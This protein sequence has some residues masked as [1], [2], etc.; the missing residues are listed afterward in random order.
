MNLFAVLPAYNEAANLPPLLASLSGLENKLKPEVQLHVIVVDDGSSDGTAGTVVP[1]KNFAE[2]VQHAKNQGFPAALR[3]GL[4]R[5]LELSG[6]DDAV[7]VMDADNTHPVDTIPPMAAKLKEGFDVVIASRYAPGGSQKGVSLFRVILSRI[8]GW[9]LAGFFPVENVKDFT[10]SFRLIR[11]KTL[12]A[13]SEKTGGMFY[14]EESFVCACEFLF[15]L[16]SAGAR[17]AEV[18]LNLRYDM[19]VGK[20]KMNVTKTV[21]GYFK[22]MRR[23]G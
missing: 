15:N 4:R 7:L 13:L 19:R 17:F 10:S 1:F 3:T 14:V 2:A 8:C 18:P 23:L 5:A 22:L 12:R 11:A 20:S 9:I 6:P 21:L 16:K